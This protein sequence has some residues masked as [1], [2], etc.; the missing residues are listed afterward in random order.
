MYAPQREGDQ[1]DLE[2]EDEEGGQHD[3]EEL[4]SDALKTRFT[5]EVG[6]CT[7]FT[8]HYQF[9][10]VSGGT[11]SVVLTQ[12]LNPMARTIMTRI[13]LTMAS[14]MMVGSRRMKR[15]RRTMMA[16]TM[17]MTM[18]TRTSTMT[19]RKGTLDRVTINLSHCIMD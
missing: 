4:N 19:C 18:V 8:A 6:S 12:K 11:V 1:Q 2:D 9:F 7:S 10:S 16:M 3:L 13:T 15:R 17:A 5:H 14:M